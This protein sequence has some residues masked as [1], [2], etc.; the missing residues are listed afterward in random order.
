MEGTHAGVKSMGGE[1][2]AL[3]FIVTFYDT[4]RCERG[5]E[6]QKRG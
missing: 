2:K 6:R 4:W 1:K 3:V 5:D